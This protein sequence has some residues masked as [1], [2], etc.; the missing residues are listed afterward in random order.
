M[1]VW[2]WGC[3]YIKGLKIYTPTL[4]GRIAS[5]LYFLWYAFLCFK[6]SLRGHYYFFNQERVMDKWIKK[7]KKDPRRDVI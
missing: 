4:D 3:V 1:S 6:N 5:N 2:V 7:E